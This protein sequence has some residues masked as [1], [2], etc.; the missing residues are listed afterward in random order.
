MHEV[1]HH[2]Q[3]WLAPSTTGLEPVVERLPYEAPTPG[4]WRTLVSPRSQDRAL[5][6]GVDVVLALGRAT[7]GRPLDI[8]ATVTGSLYLHLMQGRIELHGAGP[9]TV[10]L[11]DGDAIVFFDGAPQLRMLA[12]DSAELLRFNSAAVDPRTGLTAPTT[13][14]A[15]P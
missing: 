6:I 2:F 12:A 1:D 3:L 14:H 5:D 8:P 9:D 10:F 15:N 11:Q 7:P 13:L 4:A